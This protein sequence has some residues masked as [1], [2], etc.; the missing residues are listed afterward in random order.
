MFVTF[1]AACVMAAINV[2]VLAVAA[3]ANATYLTILLKSF[4]MHVCCC[5]A[6]A[7]LRTRDTAL[8][9]HWRFSL[10]F[11]KG[12]ITPCIFAA[13]LR[14]DIVASFDFALYLL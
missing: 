4:L 10:G 9:A 8:P 12:E 11:K 13:A 7:C 2:S 6:L 1:A 3:A 5:V 14:I